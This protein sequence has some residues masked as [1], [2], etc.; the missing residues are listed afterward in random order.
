MTEQEYN[1]AASLLTEIKLASS[2]KERALA[3]L[4]YKNFYEALAA[5][6]KVVPF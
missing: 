4:S 3:T 5:K 2:N 6:A 1:L